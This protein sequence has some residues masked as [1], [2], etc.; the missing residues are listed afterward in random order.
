MVSKRA[1]TIEYAIRDIVVPA[2][3]LEKQGH[4]ILKL[5][6]GDPN[7]Y[8][9]DTPQFIKDAL[10][11]AVNG[12]QNWYSASQGTEEVR[13]AIAEREK[14]LK[15]VDVDPD[16]IIVTS[17]VSEGLL[18]LF[19]SLVEDGDEVLIPGPSYPPYI[20]F[21]KFFGG[22]PVEYRTIEEEGWEIDLDDL[23]R[24]ITDRTKAMVVINPNNP[25][26]ACYSEHV[27]K[28][29]VDI[30][31]AH[32]IP[33]ISDEI[34]DLMTYNEPTSLAKIAKG[35]PHVLLNGISKVY[36]AP[37][38]RL[39]FMAFNKLDEL[40]EACMRQA[41]IRLCANA[42]IQHAYAKALLGPHEHIEETKKKLLERRDF[43]WKR[44][45]EINGLS[46]AK[47]E[48]AFYMFPKIE[49]NRYAT[50]K[51]W[52]L[53][54]LKQK[55]VLTVNGSGFGKEYGSGHFRIVYLPPIE[56]LEEA[57]NRIEEF[58]KGN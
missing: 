50:D 8:D 24:K 23:E 30:A 52:V 22:R 29:I 39:G 7:K 3:E 28:K 27:L 2:T 12:G 45:N 48:G 18:F 54:L 4:K 32:E 41:R 9:F 34:Y 49:Q 21:V 15:C 5:N 51:E 31:A 14:K 26:G 40:Y 35:V 46:S 57:F 53:E 43:A 47:P 1:S 25:T 38:W 44:V 33:I 10:A 37:G 36:L 58:M 56:T 11:D 16:R 42:P 20:S 55:H 6:I 13:N 17:G 19:G